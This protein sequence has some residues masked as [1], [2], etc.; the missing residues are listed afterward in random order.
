MDLIFC[1]GSQDQTAAAPFA[2]C[3]R[4]GG[5]AQH[6]LICFVHKD[7]RNRRFVVSFLRDFSRC[8]RVTTIVS[9]LQEME[10][11]SG[12]ASSLSKN[13]LDVIQSKA[14]DLLFQC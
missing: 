11:L 9:K 13:I 10:G 12:R 6:S 5:Y 4:Q 7:A 8:T 2:G 1:A 3:L 14:R